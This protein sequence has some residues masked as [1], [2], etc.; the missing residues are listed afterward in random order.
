[1]HEHILG[2][3]K[4]TRGETLSQNR[5]ECLH[6]PQT[7]HQRGKVPRLCAAFCLGIY[8]VILFSYDVASSHVS[9]YHTTEWHALP[10][11]VTF[12]P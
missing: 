1:M 10:F 6:S 12:T 2:L 4:R 9:V 3:W 7:T 5:T 11:S 8:T